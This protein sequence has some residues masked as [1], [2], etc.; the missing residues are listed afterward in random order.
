[1]SS[2][3][4][5]DAFFATPARN[6]GIDA[7]R[8]LAI[9]LVVLHHIGL[10]LPLRKGLL[11]DVVPLPLLNG[12]N[13]NGYEAVFVFFV[14]SGFL[15][16][17]T[18]LQHWGSLDRIDAKSFYVRRVAR[19]V[20]CLML[21]IG[22]LA[23][24]HLAGAAD[25]V[26]AHEGQSLPRAITAALGLHLNWYEGA[27]GY[28]P[29]GWDVLWSLS[30]EEV[31]YLAFPLL[32]LLLRRSGWLVCILLALA[33]SLPCTRAALDGNEIWQEKA[34]LPGMSAIAT[35]V[36][37]ALFAAKVRPRAWLIRLLLA[38]GS[39]GLAAVLF[40]EGWLWN[41]LGNGTMLV[42]TSA[43]ACLVVGLH[44]RGDC[45]A[46]HALKGLGW[47]RSF[48]RLSYEIYLTHMFVVFAFVAMFKASGGD[49]RYGVLWYLPA[50]P[51]TWLLG[52]ALAR[53]F[54]IPCDRALRRLLLKRPVRAPV[55]EATR[56]TEKVAI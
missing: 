30:I 3:D 6:A 51:L 29:G 38:L 10:R 8:G 14:L 48:G 34:Y 44:W 4:P 39:A 40:V 43:T 37:A 2:E 20:P 5:G 32:C 54:S 26:I 52:A 42:L 9:V 13:Y 12:L 23:L 15:I 33:L 47:L 7:L 1:M 24:L 11:A 36:L 18:S 22:V 56:T 45:G 53:G 25:Y 19:I 46:A 55:L 21:L 31:F 16:A 27:T 28:L 50:V 49:L 41:G 17:T 35:G